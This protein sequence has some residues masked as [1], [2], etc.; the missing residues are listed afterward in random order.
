MGGIGSGFEVEDVVGY[1]SCQL[2][3]LIFDILV[4]IPATRAEALRFSA[5]ALQ[6]D[7]AMKRMMIRSCMV[8]EEK[9]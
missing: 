9:N 8:E 1:Y 2:G 3:F 4:S 7:E 6:A 5:T